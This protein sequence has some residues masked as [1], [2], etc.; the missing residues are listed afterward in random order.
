MVSRVDENDLCR[1]FDGEGGVRG[2]TTRHEHRN[3]MAL[4]K[5]LGAIAICKLAFIKLFHIARYL[6]IIKLI[7]SLLFV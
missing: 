1:R 7:Y 3:E 2:S 4:C 5:L 6:S